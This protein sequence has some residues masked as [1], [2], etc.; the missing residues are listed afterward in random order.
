MTPPFISILTFFTHRL[1][2]ITVVSDGIFACPR[3]HTY[4]RGSKFEN[5]MF[6]WDPIFSMAPLG[7]SWPYHAIRPHHSPLPPS[8]A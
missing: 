7:S 5:Y 1:I 8:T 3:Q 6:S 4:L 2:T